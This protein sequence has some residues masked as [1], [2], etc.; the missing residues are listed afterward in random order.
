MRFRRYFV[1]SSLGE[2]GVNPEGA[3]LLDLEDPD[4]VLRRTSSR[5]S[6]RPP[7][8]ERDGFVGDVVFPTGLVETGDTLLV[9]YGAADACT[10]VVELSR[11]EVFGALQ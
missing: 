9:Y 10:A 11:H 2:V 5:L 8:F 6:P 4:R 7:P 3:L 1:G